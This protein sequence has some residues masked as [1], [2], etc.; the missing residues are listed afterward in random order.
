MSIFDTIMGQ[1]GGS[2]GQ[3][4]EQQ[5]AGMIAQKMGIDP[6]MAQMAIGALMKNH[7]QPNDTVQ[8]S[9]EQTG[10]APDMMSQILGQLGGEGALTSLLGAVSG[11][12]TPGEIDAAGGAAGGGLA[13]ALTGMLGGLMGGKKS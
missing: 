3:A 5:V 13:G 10:I 1:M 6:A 9:A 12:Q 2:V 11:Q 8:A 4:V 7:P